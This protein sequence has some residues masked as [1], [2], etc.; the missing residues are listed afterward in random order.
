VDGEV[1]PI[2]NRGKIMTERP[3]LNKSLD[4]ATFQSYY[5][6][7]EELTQFCR[8]EG[9]QTTGG[10]AD[11][12]KRIAH[13]LDTGEKLVSKTNSKTPAVVGNITDDT[14]IEDNF[15]CSEKHRAY[16]VQVI[17]KKFSFNVAFQKWLKANTGKTYKE[18]IGA[19][20]QILTEKKTSKTEIDK[21]FEYNT[22]IRDFFADN[23]GNSLADAIKCWKYKKS[24]RGHNIYEKSDLDALKSDSI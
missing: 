9:L 5:Y 10:K 23:N 24:V 12:S 22:Y 21:Q 16:F 19:Y 18:A 6:L 8:Q 17:G 4:G 2:L 3:D 20:H 11:I 13:Y 1:M 15:V 14:L 7:K